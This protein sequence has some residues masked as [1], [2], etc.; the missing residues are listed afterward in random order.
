MALQQVYKHSGAIGPAG[1]LVPALGAVGALV[2]SIVYGYISVYN[3]IAGY[4]SFLI[5]GAFAFGLVM[6]MSVL[7]K[8]GKCRN[9]GFL[10]VMGGLI[11]ALALYASWVVF[12]YA[13]I[14]RSY[15]D[16]ELNLFAMFLSPS[17]IW[18]TIL[19][20]NETGW[21]TIKS[22]TPSGV[23]L[24]IFW[25]IEAVI[26]AG[27]PLVF[28]AVGINDEVFCERCNQW[29]DTSDKFQLALPSDASATK[30][31]TDG[32]LETLEGLNRVDAGV[33]PRLDVT[34]HS[35]QDCSKSAV[36]KVEATRLEVNKDGQASE[37]NDKVT[38]LLMLSQDGMQR[39]KTLS[40]KPIEVTTAEPTE[41]P[42]PEEPLAT[43]EAA[44]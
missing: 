11:G 30:Q 1:I 40:A 19:D 37:K 2:L 41:S 26:I 17:D 3:P 20:I 44:E 24:W 9:A 22:A 29:C 14:N 10:H 25:G 15:D 7:A 18:G 8:T 4:I 16:A 42:E 34:V 39:L 43:T 31:I 23:I 38:E 12:I 21:F 36:Y 13:L 27:A 5:T 33:Y 32:S 6:L 28:G 35:C